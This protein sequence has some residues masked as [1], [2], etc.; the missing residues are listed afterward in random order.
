MPDRKKYKGLPEGTRVER[1]PTRIFEEKQPEFDIEYG[2]GEVT[3]VV[4]LGE[5]QMISPAER[6]RD[7]LFDMLQRDREQ[8]AKR[9]ELF[10]RRDAIRG[11]RKAQQ[12]ALQRAQEARAIRDEHGMIGELGAEMRRRPTGMQ[13]IETADGRRLRVPHFNPRDSKSIAEFQEE[14][15]KEEPRFIDSVLQYMNDY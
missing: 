3:P 6:K 8:Q 12:R 15:R 4:E 9:N 2:S 7:R 5:A 14:V 13:T 10:E 11:R 1:L